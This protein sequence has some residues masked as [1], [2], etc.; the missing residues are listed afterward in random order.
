VTPKPAP[1][2]L[3]SALLFAL[4]VSLV[5]LLIHD[6]GTGTA[7]PATGITAGVVPAPVA[8]ERGNEEEIR[9]EVLATRPIDEQECVTESIGDPAFASN[10]PFESPGLNSSIGVGGGAGGLFGGRRG[11]HKFLKLEGGVAGPEAGETSG[12]GTSSFDA[13]LETGFA[14]PSGQGALSTFSVDV[15]TASYAIVRRFLLANGSL[16]PR[17]AVRVEEMVNY[18]RYEDAP[19]RNGDALVPRVDAA[20]CPW[21]PRHRLV[22]V[23]LKAREVAE[24]ERPPANLVFLVDVSGSMASD[25]KLPLAKKSLA[26]LADRLTARDRVAIVVYA[27][28][29]GLALPSTPGDRR[30][31]FLA[32]VER[33]G[34]GGS[35]NGG[36]GITLAYRIAEENFVRGGI[37]RVI[38]ATD[39]DLNVGVTSTSDLV[40]LVE[41]KAKGGVYLTA[42]GFGMDNLR[43]SMLV[44]LADR[45]NGNYGHVDSLAEARKVLVE[46]GLSNIMAVAKDAKIQVEW[47]PRTVAAWRL[48]G[49]EKRRLEAKDFR[50]DAKDAG[51]VGAGHSVT[52]FYEVV[53]A[54]EPVPGAPVDG[55]RYQ[56]VA[57]DSASDDLLTVK[58]RWKD[59]E[60]PGVHE[61]ERSYA[62]G[63]LAFD[64]APTDFRFAASVAAF[65][66][67]LRGSESRGDASLAMVREIAA[68]ALGRDEGGYR[69]EF[70]AMVDR[71]AA[72]TK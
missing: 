18:F 16:P 56:R 36:A 28:R 43:D 39:G 61:V 42:L 7:P 11:G 33:M 27:G 41:K 5:L 6:P 29:E 12:Y 19:P 2:L 9:P 32:A 3:P 13:I 49:Y 48:V 69:G 25:D 51:E 44:Q 52:A 1:R 10:A 67:V 60:G 53:P 59:P 4:T 14:V 66:M 24:E 47:N 70:V 31:D 65:A 22:R 64:A 23:A 50:D 37:N 35:T 34:A 46:D 8:L 62:D 40:D 38:L 21:A 58:V 63:G 57:D 55:L 15:D 45:G 20:S 68:G 26:L 17:G 30:A 54:G 72:V 71:A